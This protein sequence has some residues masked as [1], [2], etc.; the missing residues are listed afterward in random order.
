MSNAFGYASQVLYCTD[1]YVQYMGKVSPIG[2]A[3]T[4]INANLLLYIYMDEHIR[5][6]KKKLQ[7][8]TCKKRKRTYVKL[9]VQKQDVAQGYARATS[10][11]R[12]VIVLVIKR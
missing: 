11:K 1:D 10:F 9:Y 6:E 12:I 3:S 4:A 7:T 8:N 2:R 5:P